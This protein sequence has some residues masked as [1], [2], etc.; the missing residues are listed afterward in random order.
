[1]ELP[2]AAE[3]TDAARKALGAPNDKQLA[4]LLWQRY[5][6]EAD[7]PKV[8]RWRRGVRA[9]NFDATMTLLSAAGWID[10]EA[11]SRDRAAAA[12]AEALA[13][14]QEAEETARRQ[15]DRRARPRDRRKTA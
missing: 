3:V 4:F 6:L 13:A 8:S 2:T 12:R 15:A 14:A 11:I 9:P 10:E 7:Q 5:G 1:M